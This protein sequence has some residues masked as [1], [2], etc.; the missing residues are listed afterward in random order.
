MGG[1]RT[2]PARLIEGGVRMR[3]AGVARQGEPWSGLRFEVC[4]RSCG[5]IVMEWEVGQ[6]GQ[7]IDAS[8]DRIHP[9][10]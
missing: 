5:G 7:R 2:F 1:P 10:R 6:H 4:C 3:P 9:D 8:T